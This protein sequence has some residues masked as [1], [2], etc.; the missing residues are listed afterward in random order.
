MTT[1]DL[2][3]LRPNAPSEHTKQRH[4][5]S[6]HDPFSIGDLLSTGAKR[7]QFGGAQHDVSDQAAQ[8]HLADVRDTLLV[9]C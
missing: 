6:R 7:L 4:E 3:L 2:P 5:R 9:C 8:P 1:F